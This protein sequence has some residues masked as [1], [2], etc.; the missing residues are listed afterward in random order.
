MPTPTVSR[1]FDSTSAVASIFAASTGGRCGNT[2][3]EVSRRMRVVTAA[4]CAIVIDC[5]RHSPVSAAGQ[6][7]LSL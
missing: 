1:P 3:T 2:I 5:S 7:P 4:T 6:A